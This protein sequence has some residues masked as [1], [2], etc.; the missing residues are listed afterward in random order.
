MNMLAPIG[1]PESPSVAV[2]RCWSVLEVLDDDDALVRLAVGWVTPTRLRVTSP[3]ERF[4]GGQ[5]LTRTGS[6]YTLDGPPASPQDLVEQKTR[7]D[8]LLGGRS[9][10]DVTALYLA[11]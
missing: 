7:R 3:L 2:L 6:I 8:A 4:E 9:A 5:V 11:A 1:F 10:I